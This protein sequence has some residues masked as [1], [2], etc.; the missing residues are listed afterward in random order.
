MF[1]GQKTMP[2]RPFRKFVSEGRPTMEGMD[3]VL[4]INVFARI[5]TTQAAM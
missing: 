2:A 5:A 4:D 3:R 1:A